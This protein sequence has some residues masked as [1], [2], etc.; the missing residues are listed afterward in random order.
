[1]LK[2]LFYLNEILFCLFNYLSVFL[3]L[4]ILFYSI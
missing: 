2:I 1:M 4:V 3:Y